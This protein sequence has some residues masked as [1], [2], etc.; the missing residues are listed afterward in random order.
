MVKHRDEYRP[1][2]PYRS[3]APQFFLTLAGIAVLIFGVLY[4]ITWS[5]TRHVR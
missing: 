2:R 4:F 3:T 5:L 1:P